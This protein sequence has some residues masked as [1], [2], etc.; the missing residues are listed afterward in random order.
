M[1]NLIKKGWFGLLT[2]LIFCG[3][4]STPA[5]AREANDGF[6]IATFYYQIKEPEFT[7]CPPPLGPIEFSYRD[8]KCYK[9]DSTSTDHH[10]TITAQEYLNYYFG[11]GKVIHAGI[12]P[13]GER[14]AVIRY[15]VIKPE[16]HE[17][18][19]HVP[20]IL[21]Y[22]FADGDHYFAERELISEIEKPKRL[23]NRVGTIA[24]FSLEV[25]SREPITFTDY[26][27]LEFTDLELVDT[28]NW[29]VRDDTP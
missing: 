16:H 24:G 22:S 26:E 15:R 3:V 25:K 14:T 6:V 13:A 21:V 4:T 5:H 27:L 18:E 11:P 20:R 17:K 10:Q 28:P 1:Q 9:K 29:L 8:G 23:K 2:V 7:F 12:D 19:I